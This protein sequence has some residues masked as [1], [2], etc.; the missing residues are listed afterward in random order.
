MLYGWLKKV[1][2]RRSEAVATAYKGS[3]RKALIE[4]DPRFEIAK[5]HKGANDVTSE[6]GPTRF[7][8]RMPTA[9]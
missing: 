1:F 8:F 4:K 6:G 2:K 3:A 5:A 9:T 7:T